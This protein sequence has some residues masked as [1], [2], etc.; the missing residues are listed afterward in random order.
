VKFIRDSREIISTFDASPLASRWAELFDNRGHDPAQLTLAVVKDLTHFEQL[1]S[2][3]GGIDH[4]LATT[5]FNWPAVFAFNPD[6]ISLILINGGNIHAAMQLRENHKV[7]C[8]SGH[9]GPLVYVSFLEIAPWNRTGHPRRQF[10]GLGSLMLELASH[11]SME[12]GQGGALGL[13]ALPDAVPFY[14]KLD[15]AAVPCPNEH[16]ELYFE[17]DGQS[18]TGFR[19]RG[20][21]K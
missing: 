13:Y 11:W 12:R 1:Y 6:A 2:N 8:V 14:L 3:W 19:K 10:S 17:M 7:R 4:G 15:F 16:N 5:Q 21:L 20:G 9:R 18:A